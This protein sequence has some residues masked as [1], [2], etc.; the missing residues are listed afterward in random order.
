MP[1]WSS[2][3]Q[4]TY[5]VVLA[6]LIALVA[7]FLNCFFLGYFDYG[8]V[9]EYRSSSLAITTLG[10]V[11]GINPY[12]PEYVEAYGNVYSAVW[13]A[14]VA[15]LAL[16]T[17]QTSFDDIRFLMFV[18]NAAIVLATMTVAIHVGIRNG[19]GILLSL[20]IGFTY[21]L[22]NTT[23]ISMGE[24]SFAVGL[25]CTFLALLAANN[26]F[27]EWGY[28][29]ALTLIT[30]ASLCKVYFAIL[31]IPVLFSYAAVLRTR[32][33]FFIAAI[34]GC[35]TAGLYICLSLMF[36]YYL[37]G[38]VFLQRRS[39]TWQPAHILNNIAWF[40]PRFGFILL[41]LIPKLSTFGRIPAE[42]KR[43]ELW[44]AAG[45]VVIWIFVFFVLLAHIGN[46]G[47]YLLHLVAP[48]ILAYSLAA[49]HER[50][51]S[52]SWRWFPQFAVA[53]MGLMVFTNPKAL[54]GMSDRFVS[55]QRW[56][57]YGV[58]WRDEL[59][60]N[61]MIFSKINLLI[62]QNPDKKIV[63]DAFFSRQA[64][65]NKLPFVDSG[66]RTYFID[67]LYA[68]N[69]GSFRPS[70]PF[71]LLTGPLAPNPKFRT[72]TDYQLQAD[73]VISAL[74]G[75]QSFQQIE[76]LGELTSSY[77]GRLD[78]ILSAVPHAPK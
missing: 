1:H 71:S 65:N 30:L 46:L 62:R 24:F 16:A 41:F 31:C 7:A 10:L 29:I 57:R 23:N 63:L 21:F 40:A 66:H 68:K 77:N 28:A 11:Q 70:F 54:V 51:A 38:I 13:P 22:L 53:V 72:I 75:D 33:F 18:I 27:D 74:E 6:A 25:S 50:M 76:T 39:A 61:K 69:N 60:A 43:R 42:K 12:S 17:G 64:I 32:R 35:A 3:N 73:W 15:A 59:N 26:R 47:T 49:P 37:D 58:V 48:S 20:A 4:L 36:P 56:E 55:L 9:A 2:L 5:Y 52:R 14:L 67:Y 8:F 44:F 34:W 78:V 19:L 45:N